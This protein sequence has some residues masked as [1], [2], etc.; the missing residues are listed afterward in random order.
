MD[1]RSPA[2]SGLVDYIRSVADA[3]GDDVTEVDVDFDDGLATAIILVRSHVP[4]LLE[5]PLLL[6]WDEVSGWALRVETDGTGDTTALEFL[7]GD[8]LPHPQVV[9]EFLGDA[10]C[11]RSPGLVLPPAF[12]TPNAGDELEH[13]L[14]QFRG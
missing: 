2:A 9:R 4:T 6:T 10:V 7:G 11:G 12:R 13:R 14:A 1:T 3:L 5:L 8:I